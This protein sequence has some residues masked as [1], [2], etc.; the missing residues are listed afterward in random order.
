MNQVERICEVL[1]DELS[2]PVFEYT[3]PDNYAKQCIV[4][5]QVSHDYEYQEGEYHINIYVP[6]KER[7]VDGQIDRSCPNRDV[8]DDIHNQVMTVVRGLW[9]SVL[10]INVDKYQLMKGEGFMHYLNICLTIQ[11]N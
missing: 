8:M 7:T 2:V 1:R 5:N 6:N 3:L 4:V 10:D 9:S 11:F